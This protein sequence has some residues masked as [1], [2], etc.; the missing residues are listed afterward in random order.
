MAMRRLIRGTAVLAL[1]A[2]T[3][4]S[5]YLAYFFIEGNTSD[6]ALTACLIEPQRGSGMHVDFEWWPLP[7]TYKCLY[8]DRS[9]KVVDSRRLSYSDWLG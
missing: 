7:P 1:G 3:L 2:I 4:L 9:G 8:T 5:A 6:T